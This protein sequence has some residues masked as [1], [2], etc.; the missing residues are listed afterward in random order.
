MGLGSI[1]SS[2]GAAAAIAAAWAPAAA[3]ASLA[4]FGANAVPASAGIAATTAFAY[5]LSIPAFAKGG[6]VDRPTLA[7]I[8]EAGPEAVVPLSGSRAGVG[9]GVTIV[10]HF[11]LSGSTFLSDDLPENVKRNLTIYIQRA[12]VTGSFVV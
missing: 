6:I 2:Y 7:L 1:A 9:G 3:M 11:D 12:I 8:G 5:M 4:S 10:N